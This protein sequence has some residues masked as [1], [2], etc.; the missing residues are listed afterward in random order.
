V[1][2]SFALIIIL[3]GSRHGGTVDRNLCSNTARSSERRAGA[4]ENVN[5]R[6]TREFT[7]APAAGKPYE[8]AKA[9]VHG[10]EYMGTWVHGLGYMGTWVRV[11][12]YMG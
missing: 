2:E 5:Q 4:A 6:S 3:T 12:G 9:G 11:H 7:V 1:L 8:L 10:L